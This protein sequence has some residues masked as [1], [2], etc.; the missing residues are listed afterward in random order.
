MSHWGGPRTWVTGEAL[1]SGHLN[2]ELMVNM[3]ATAPAKAQA[4]GDIFV[5]TGPNRIQRLAIGEDEAVLTADSTTTTGLKWARLLQTSYSVWAPG[6]EQV[7]SSSNLDWP[8]T[9]NKLPGGV[10]IS[11]A[12]FGYMVSSIVVPSN[13]GE[14]ISLDAVVFC[15]AG[16]E[17]SL[18][19]T[20]KVSILADG[21]T[22][23]NPITTEKID[24][25]GSTTVATT[26]AYRLNL[27]SGLYR[28][29]LPYDMIGIQ[30]YKENTS[31]MA[32][33]HMIGFEMKYTGAN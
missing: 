32:G 12:S 28:T 26:Q 6:W 4:A 17:G 33:V 29:L 18:D 31:D 9:S 13:F 20:G 27:L 10:V 14:I 25:S 15:E 11:A 8:D 5:G 24:V 7:G 23:A 3:N 16:S 19:W 1:S 30:W 21:A 22:F 2:T